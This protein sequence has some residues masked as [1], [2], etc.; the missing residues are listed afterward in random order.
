MGKAVQMPRIKVLENRIE[1][2]TAL[3][4]QL[5]AVLK[6][7]ERLDDEA[8][9]EICH[10]SQLALHWYGPMLGADTDHVGRAACAYAEGYVEDGIRDEM[11]AEIKWEEAQFDEAEAAQQV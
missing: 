1:V 5:L 11:V 6:A 10:G 2:L 3:V 9:V 4:A 7:R 8:L